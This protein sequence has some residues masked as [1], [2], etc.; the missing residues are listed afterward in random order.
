MS[1][2]IVGTLAVLA[3]SLGLSMESLIPA[4]RRRWAAVDRFYA[5]LD[6][7]TRWEQALM[8]HQAVRAR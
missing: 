2:L 7:P 5:W 6:R 1:D 4:A 3:F 8:E